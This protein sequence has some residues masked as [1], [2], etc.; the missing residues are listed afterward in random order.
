MNSSVPPTMVANGDGNQ[1]RKMSAAAKAASTAVARKCRP[2]ANNFLRQ[3]LKP[4]PRSIVETHAAAQALVALLPRLG[5]QA[6]L[7]R[8]TRRLRGVALARRDQRTPDQLQQLPLGVA[9]V[10]LL[11]ARLARHDQQFTGVVQPLTGEDTQ[12]RLGVFAQRH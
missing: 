10:L 7:L 11:A 5:I 2:K 4:G 8:S 12:P 9:A 3:M 1:T 6:P